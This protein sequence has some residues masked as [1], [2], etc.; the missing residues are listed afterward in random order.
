[1]ERELK[2]PRKYSRSRAIGI[3]EETR[4]GYTSARLLHHR[5][6]VYVPKD[7]DQE[8]L[9]KILEKMLQPSRDQCPTAECCQRS[10]QR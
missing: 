1:M 2:I 5:V 3:G 7:L 10:V 6:G 4:H 9:M 8:I